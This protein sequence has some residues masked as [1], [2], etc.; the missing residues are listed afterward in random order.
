MA[1]I[2]LALDPV[3]IHLG[4]SGVYWYGFA[5]T[6][7]FAILWLW[8][9]RRR[10]ALGWS[11]DEVVTACMAFVI[12]VLAGGRIVEVIFYEWSW[13]RERPFE[14]PMLWKGGMATHGLL[15]GAVLTAALVSRLTRTPWLVLLDELTP[16]AAIILGLGRIGNFIEGGVIGTPTDLPW[17]VAIPGVQ[18]FRHPVSLYDGLKNLALVPVLLAVLRRWPAGSGMATGTFCLAYGGL[19]FLVD[20]LRD[21]E[22]DLYGMG[23]GQ[24]LNL[25]MAAIGAIVLIARRNAGA[26]TTPKAEARPARPWKT[27]AL[28]VLILFPLTIPT[29]WTTTY[30]EIKRAP[31]SVE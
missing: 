23:P 29:S 8:L 6:V 25:A 15:A 9:A 10:D 22:S 3:M 4:S 28:V 7:G 13:Y 14:I 5:Y 24:W 2:V 31:S 1:G 16:P 18:G 20:Q 26:A 19:R 27:V 17:G 12:G 21:Y 11:S 30:L